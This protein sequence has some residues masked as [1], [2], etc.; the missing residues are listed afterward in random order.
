MKVPP[1]PCPERAHERAKGKACAMPKARKVVTHPIPPVD[2]TSYVVRT[3]PPRPTI[4]LESGIWMFRHRIIDRRGLHLAVMAALTE[5]GERGGRAGAP[6]PG[7]REDRGAWL[8]LGCALCLWA[9]A[10]LA[11]SCA[12]LAHDVA[13][14]TC[15]G[16][17]G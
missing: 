17:P 12:C 8:G 9:Q 13:L 16:P 7:G 10:G 15:L 6:G 2:T 1:W 14:A 4:R 5:T 11:A 3:A